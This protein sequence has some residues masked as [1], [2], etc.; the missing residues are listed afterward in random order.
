MKSNAM[1]LEEIIASA[2]SLSINELDDSKEFNSLAGWDSMTHMI[3][4]TDMESAFG[5]ELSGDE[6]ADMRTIGDAR[7]ILKNHGAAV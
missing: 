6:I 7:R 3:L 1:T 2:L 5:V 4:I